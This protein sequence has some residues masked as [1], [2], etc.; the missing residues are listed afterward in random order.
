MESNGIKNIN[1]IFSLEI[2]VY[3][4]HYKKTAINIYKTADWCM[5]KQSRERLMYFALNHLFSITN[6]PLE[7]GTS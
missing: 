4:K 2:I 5:Y 3:L 6:A 1:L 7:I